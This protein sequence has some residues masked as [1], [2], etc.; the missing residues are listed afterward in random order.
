MRFFVIILV[1][2]AIHKVGS[3]QK[4][5]YKY[6]K[7]DRLIE[8]DYPNQKAINYNYDKDGNRTS[9]VISTVVVTSINDLNDSLL[10]KKNGLFVYQNPSCV[11]VLQRREK[12][13]FSDILFTWI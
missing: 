10:L 13:N 8:V 1:L 3:A 5:Q 7:A 9:T 11:L 2:L 12:S 4:V 6:D